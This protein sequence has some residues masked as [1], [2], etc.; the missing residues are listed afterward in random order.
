[1]HDK[2]AKATQPHSQPRLDG[3]QRQRQLFCTALMY[4]STFAIAIR[5]IFVMHVLVYIYYALMC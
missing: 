1:M 5:T 4:Q 2:H 3:R